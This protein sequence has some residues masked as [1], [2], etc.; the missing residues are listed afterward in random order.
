MARRL[1]AAIVGGG[2]GDLCSGRRLIV[3]MKRA[4][5]VLTALQACFRRRLPAGTLGHRVLCKR[6]NADD[7]RHSSQNRPH[8]PRMRVRDRSVKRLPFARSRVRSG[9]STRTLGIAEATSAYSNVRHA[10]RGHGTAAGGRYAGG[11][12][13]LEAHVMTRQVSLP[14]RAPRCRH[15]SRRS[16]APQFHL[17]GGGRRTLFQR[18]GPTSV[19]ATSWQRRSLRLSL[20]PSVGEAAGRTNS[21]I[22]EIVAGRDD[23]RTAELVLVLLRA[24]AGK[25]RLLRDLLKRTI[26]SLRLYAYTR[27]PTTSV[28]LCSPISSIP[29][30]L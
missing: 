12:N 3:M 17:R 6:E 11:H 24:Y 8:T 30:D 19:V 10:F 2:L 4:C 13:I 22:A 21:L 1:R 14:S 28:D 16:P 18:R 27:A 29:S 7:R 26:P 25:S 9:T 15:E 5:A 23:Q 20:G